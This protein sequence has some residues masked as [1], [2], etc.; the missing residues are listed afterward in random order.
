[1]HQRISI[2]NAVV[3]MYSDVLGQASPAWIV[4]TLYFRMQ[5]YIHA[6]TGIDT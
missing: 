4:F 6:L 5:F 3:K 1:M 2:Q